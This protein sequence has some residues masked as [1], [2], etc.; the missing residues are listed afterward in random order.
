MLTVTPGSV[1][2]KLDK[3]LCPQPPSASRDHSIVPKDR[4]QEA[5]GTIE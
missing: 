4:D 5:I 3:I 1:T 2:G